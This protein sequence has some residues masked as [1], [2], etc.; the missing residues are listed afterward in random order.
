MKHQTRYST[1]GKNLLKTHQGKFESIPRTVIT[2][3]RIYCVAFAF[4][5]T[6]ICRF[7]SPITIF[8]ISS[9]NLK[10]DDKT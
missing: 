6:P 2:Y 5:Y 1:R 3:D 10:I 8:E 9:E 7:Y 4:N